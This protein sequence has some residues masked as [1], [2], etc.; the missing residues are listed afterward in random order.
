MSV[1]VL[2]TDQTLGRVHRDGPH[3]VLAKVLRHFEDQSFAVVVGFQRV[4]NRGQ[5]AIELHVDDGADDLSDF[6]F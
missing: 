2:T 4:Q 5:I 3:R 6:A 1:T